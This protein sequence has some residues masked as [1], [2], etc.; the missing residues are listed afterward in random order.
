MS[1]STAVS[2]PLLKYR[3]PECAE[4]FQ[5]WSTCLQHL[6]ATGHANPGY[7]QGLQQR[8]MTGSVHVKDNGHAT[9]GNKQCPDCA[10]L[11]NERSTCLEHL[12]ATGHANSG[13]NGCWM[14]GSRVGDSGGLC[15]VF[16]VVDFIKRRRRGPWSSS[17]VHFHVVSSNIPEKCGK[18]KGEK[19]GRMLEVVKEV[20][21]RRAAAAAT[22]R[23]EMASQ[24]L[25]GLSSPN[26]EMGLVEVLEPHHRAY[27]TAFLVDIHESGQQNLVRSVPPSPPCQTVSS[28]L[29]TLVPSSFLTL[30]IPAQIYKRNR[31]NVGRCIARACSPSAHDATR[32]GR[33]RPP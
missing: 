10:E 7:K 17:Y 16:G 5:K 6:N 24:M 19:K 22:S 15:G 25:E 28:A 29:P 1:G 3:C 13:N 31:S 27:V 32:N 4:P 30:C 8:C 20:Q 9:S 23:E 18:K 21:Q 33:L 2:D 12:R 11:F 14:R 26:N